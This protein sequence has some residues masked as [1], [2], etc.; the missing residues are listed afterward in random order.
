MEARLTDI[1]RE[2]AL[3]YLGVRGEPDAA[4]R[5]DLDRCAALRPV[6]P[7]PFRGRTSAAFFRAAGR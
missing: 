2:E 5:R 6:R 1:S 4:L 3:R 7:S